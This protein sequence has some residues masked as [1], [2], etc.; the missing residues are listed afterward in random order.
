MQGADIARYSPQ[1]TRMDTDSI[2]I[3]R[4]PSQVCPQIT[5][6]DADTS[7]RSRAIA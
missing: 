1:I 5:Q 4:I 3:H 2:A 6:M 7:Q